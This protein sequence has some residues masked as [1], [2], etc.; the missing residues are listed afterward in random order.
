MRRLCPIGL[1]VLVLALVP[2][3]ARQRDASPQPDQPIF[4]TSSTLATI[5]AVVIDDDG[6]PVTDLTKDD[7]EV[8]VSGKRQELQ[9]A[10][11]VRA[12]SPVQPT[13]APLW[14]PPSGDHCRPPAASR[15]R[16]ERVRRAEGIHDGSGR[17]H[18]DD[19]LRRRRPESLVRKHVRRSAGSVQIHRVGGGTGR[20][21]RHRPHRVGRGALQQFTTDKRLLRLAVD[22]VQ[23]DFRSRNG[24]ASFDAR[25]ADLRSGGNN[26]DRTTDR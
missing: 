12:G 16:F 20:S 1:L 24:V 19:G 9:Q 22:R 18:S 14:R 5:D 4:R 25:G 7:F 17:H 11:F 21:G 23:W 2:L 8:K 13:G 3:S 26:W 10:V 15:H 6:H